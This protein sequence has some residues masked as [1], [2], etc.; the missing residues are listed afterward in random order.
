M[1]QVVK[2]FH[3]FALML[4]AAGG[5][6]NM[7]VAMQVKRADGPPPGALVALRPYFSKVGLAG[8]LLIW[9]TGLALYAM[10]WTDTELGIVFAL[11]LIAAFLLLLA[12]ITT[13]VLGARAASEGTPPPTIMA[14]LG[15]V[16]GVLSLLT[17][18]L[19]V[20]VFG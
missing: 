20:Y 12:I 19:A 18:A 8:I 9:L 5:I 1:Y 10:Q 4:G 16:S 17:V 2:F 14:T 7:A 11:K 6:G 13:T 15:P 3:F